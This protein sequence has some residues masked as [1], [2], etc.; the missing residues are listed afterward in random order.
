MGSLRNES[1]SHSSTGG[2][3]THGASAPLSQATLE[4]AGQPA[5]LPA[6]GTSP[7]GAKRPRTPARAP[8]IPARAPRIHDRA[9]RIPDRGLRIQSRGSRILSQA[10]RILSQGPRIQSRALGFNPEGFWRNSEGFWRSPK[11][12]FVLSGGQERSRGGVLRVPARFFRPRRT[13]RATGVLPEVAVGSSTR[14]AASSAVKL[15]IS[16]PPGDVASQFGPR[17]PPALAHPGF[18]RGPPPRPYRPRPAGLPERIGHARPSH[19]RRRPPPGPTIRSGGVRLPATHHDSGT[20]RA[21]LGSPT[22]DPECP[23]KP[24]E[25]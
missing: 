18:M 21:A 13:P 3:S 1:L 10:P 5:C 12:L 9:P 22:A 11:I 6:Y 20:C 14:A 19:H 17:P 2:W 16:P 23:R 25:P 8:P 15:D 7:G 24:V 4:S